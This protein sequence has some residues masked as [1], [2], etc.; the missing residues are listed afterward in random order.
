MASSGLYR[1]SGHETFALRYAWLPKIVEAFAGNGD[2]TLF[3]DDDR[4]MVRFGVGKNMVRAMR[5][6][7][8]ACGVLAPLGSG[9]HGLTDFGRSLLSPGDGLDPYLEDDQTLWLLHWKLSTG[10]P[11]LFAWDFLLN[12]WHEPELVPSSILLAAKREVEGTALRASECS[13]RSHLSVFLHTYCPTSAADKL[14]PE[15]S[16]DSPLVGLRLVERRGIRQTPQGKAE[17]V[18]AFRRGAKPEIDNK[19]FVYALLDFWQRTAPEEKTLDFA[20]IAF[21]PGSPGQVFKLDERDIRERLEQLDADGLTYAGSSLVQ[22][23]HR[24]QELSDLVLAAALEEVY[25]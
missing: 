14:Q 25:R 22:A 16:L 20:E 4:A 23:V 7:G 24:E 6:W 12:R 10:S 15:D 18:F 1:I 13:L 9:K 17:W 5:F 8:E 2:A 21:R 11:P 19:L 3:G